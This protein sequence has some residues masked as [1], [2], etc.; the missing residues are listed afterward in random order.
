MKAIT[1]AEGSPMHMPLDD[2]KIVEK[3]NFRR[4]NPETSTERD[5]K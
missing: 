2:S 5:L 4:E 3:H 1:R